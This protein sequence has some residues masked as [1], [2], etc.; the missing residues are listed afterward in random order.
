MLIQKDNHFRLCNPSK[1][2]SKYT[3]IIDLI[4]SSQFILFPVGVAPWKPC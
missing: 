3:D 2:V 4:A 1:D